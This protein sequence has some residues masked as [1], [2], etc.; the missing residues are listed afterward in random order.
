M[1]NVGINVRQ[2]PGRG[3]LKDAGYSMKEEEDLYNQL[4]DD[5]YNNPRWY[6]D[7]L[8]Y[9]S[10]FY[11]SWNDYKVTKITIPHQFCIKK[12]KPL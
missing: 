11:V 1:K 7:N 4:L 5:V 3:F 8:D 10:S 6:L 2:H 12:T 9:L